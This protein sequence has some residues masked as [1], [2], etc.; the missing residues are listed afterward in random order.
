MVV[1]LTTSPS[2]KFR[3]GCSPSVTIK[4]L[5]RVLKQRI[6]PHTKRNR[7]GRNKDETYNKLNIAKTRI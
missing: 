5:I 6:K 7:R 1:W 3:W 2:M 4:N